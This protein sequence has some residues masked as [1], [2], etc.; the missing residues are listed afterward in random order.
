MSV[1]FKQTKNS[2]PVIKEVTKTVFGIARKLYLY[3]ANR[4]ENRFVAKNGVT[5]VCGTAITGTEVNDNGRTFYLK[6]NT[7]NGTR[8]HIE[9]EFANHKVMDVL[10]AKAADLKAALDEAAEQYNLERTTE[11]F[12]RSIFSSVKAPLPLLLCK[13]EKGPVAVI[14]KTTET[15]IFIRACLFDYISMMTSSQF[16]ASNGYIIRCCSM[17]TTADTKMF[18][19]CKDTWRNANVHVEELNVDAKH[20]II[21]NYPTITAALIE[22][23]AAYKASKDKETEGYETF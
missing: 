12:E 9:N 18:N 11:I 23:A 17:G 8:V 3:I 5:V 20:A 10:I 13:F 15:N 22:A 21:D 2:E 14:N 6:S 1:S 4:T 7:W 16:V 19:M